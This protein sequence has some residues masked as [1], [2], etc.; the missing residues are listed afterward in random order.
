M[1]RT[2]SSFT[3]CRGRVRGELVVFAVALLVRAVHVLQIRSGPIYGLYLG[4][5][6]VFDQWARGIAAGDWIGDQVFY[7][8]PLYPYLL[9]GLYALFGDSTTL[10][11]CVQAVFGAA[12][13][14]L[15]VVAGTRFLGRRVGLVA[16]AALALYPPAIF[17]DGIVQKTSLG[18]LLLCAS[19]AVAGGLA[20]RPMGR[21]AFGLGLLT[22]LLSL[23]R[24]NA[25]VL[26][27]AWIPWLAT[28]PG[29]G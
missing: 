12:A 27:V 11:L 17:F 3:F 1:T 19:L 4:D 22:G 29:H 23:V 18:L 26:S 5:A 14:A 7:Q 16:G 8:A 10:V 2:S 6:R 13:C 20:S 15:L 24:E 28:R 9:G 25:L 21:G